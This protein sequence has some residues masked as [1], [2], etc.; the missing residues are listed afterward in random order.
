MPTYYNKKN[1]G[2]NSVLRILNGSPP[3]R[4]FRG[5]MHASV[6][7]V[8][9]DR[10]GDQHITKVP[11]RCE[12]TAGTT[13]PLTGCWLECNGNQQALGSREQLTHGHVTD[14]PSLC[15]ALIVGQAVLLGVLR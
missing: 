3:A 8:T 7:P 10:R 4:P 11:S 1:S 5:V 14:Q 6:T 12:M 15:M 13:T 2:G 9:S